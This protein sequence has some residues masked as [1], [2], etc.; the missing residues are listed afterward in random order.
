MASGR[1]S[2]RATSSATAR[3]FC[4]RE[5][6]PRRGRG[7]TLGEQRHRL[8]PRDGPRA[9]PGPGRAISSG[10]SGTT[11]SPRT[12]RG[13]RLVT[14]TVSPGAAA[15][16]CVTHG[17]RVQHL[18]EVVQQ[19][20]EPSPS[21]VLVEGL[22]Y[23]SF[24]ALLADPR[25]SRRSWARRRA[26]SDTGARSTKNVPSAK[27]PD[28][29]GRDL[30]RETG[31]ARAPGP[32]DRE[33]AGRRQQRRHL[34]DLRLAADE[35]GQLRGQ[36]RRRADAG[37]SSRRDRHGRWPLGTSGAGIVLAGSA[38]RGRAAPG[39]GRGRARRRAA[40]G[41]RGRPRGPPPRGRPTCRARISSSTGRSRSGSRAMTSRAVAMASVA[42][43]DCTNSA[44]RSSSADTRS[45]S[46]RAAAAAG[47]AVGELTVGGSP[48]PSQR[49]VEQRARPCRVGR[50]DR[51]SGAVVRLEALRV[52]GRRVGDQHVTR[53]AGDDRRAHRP[54]PG[55]QPGDDLLQRV[56]R[57]RPAA[58]RP[59]TPPPAG[60]TGRP[61][62]APAAAR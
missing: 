2:S 10:P 24:P 35:G 27:S 50:P 33:Q 37:R 52:D 30:E 54:E 39:R 4:S 40:R 53:R 38:S 60:R 25:A 44:A 59:T 15:S 32:G 41:T 21:E 45:S 26:G 17:R 3:A 31:L 62:S 18:L 8:D 36:V 61:S 9:T 56:G 7:G 12:R 5:G 16:S 43:P 55:P 48:P 47:E 51:A 13:A 11:C 14:R 23:R 19:Q 58:P 22:P 46:S 6:E 34:G 1:P 20:Q 28:D 49:V 42:A 29:R 57:V